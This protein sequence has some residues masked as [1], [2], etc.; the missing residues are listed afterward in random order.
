M[1]E[2]EFLE[3]GCFKKEQLYSFIALLGF[4]TYEDFHQVLINDYNLRLNQIRTRL[5][6]VDSHEF[7]Q[8]MEKDCSDEEMEATI[9]DICEKLYKSKRIVIFGALY[10]ISIAIELQTDM[11]T[12]GKPFIQFHNYDP[13]TL[14]EDDVAII[15]SA[16][17]RYLQGFKK[18][19]VEV[20]ILN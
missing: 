10:P 12:F 5:L 18:H 11:I 6:G 7:I 4:S 1:T 15:I 20:H 17:G 19:K 3:I 9:S 8:K 14:T 16:T 13:I 2:E